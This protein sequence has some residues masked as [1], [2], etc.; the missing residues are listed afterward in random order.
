MI[1]LKALLGQG[2]PP[3]VGI[4]I[5]TSSVRLVELAQGAKGEIRLERYAAEPLPRNAVTD[6]N[7][8]NLEQVV[9]A[10]RR[11][12]KKSGTRAKHVAL[13]MPPASVITKKII[14][15]AGLQEDQLEVQVESEASQYIPFALDEVSLDF[16]VIGPAANSAD[17]I[18][19][20]LAA[21]RREKVEDRVA[22]AEASGLKATVM[23]I[24]SYAA[25]AAL[26]RVTAQLPEAGAGQ[27]IALF[28][29]GAQVTHI[30]VMLDGVTVYEREQPFGGNTLTQDIVRSYGLSF[31]EAEARKKTGDLPDNYQAELLTPFLESAAL[32]VTRAIQFFYTSTPYTRVDQL[33]LAGGCALIPGLLELVASRTRISSAVISPFKGMQIG[34]S[35][36]ESQLRLDAPAYLVACG[37][38]LRR[39]G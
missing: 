5:S 17:D 26:D 34:P 32:E 31:D 33:F 30:S 1:D 37:L 16:D 8:E 28:Q 13:G 39:F 20:M 7:I 18:E 24:E 10:V 22:I 25:R 21:S 9:E 14:L 6:G 36:R 19:V 35:V 27:V 12:W 15:P 23:D 29:I 11:V 2:N 4:D 38:A 3:L